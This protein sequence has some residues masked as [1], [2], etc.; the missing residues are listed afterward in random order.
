[1]SLCLSLQFFCSA[2]I[3]VELFTRSLHKRYLCRA[4]EIRGLCTQRWST[5][6]VYSASAIEVLFTALFFIGWRR[7]IECLKS[8]VIFLKEPLIIGLFCGKWPI[9]DKAS[10]GFLPPYTTLCLHTILHR[11][12]QSTLSTVVYQSRTPD[13]CQALTVLLQYESRTLDSCQALTVLLQYQ[14]RTLDSWHNGGKNTLY[15]TVEYCVKTQRC[16]DTTLYKVL[17]SRK[18]CIS[19]ELLTALCLYNVLSLKNT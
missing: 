10:Y 19:H 5:L 12:V 17:R 4:V 3:C 11:C 13:S 6:R 2:P 7:L 8:Q 18:H 14:S 1:M 9:K 16:K 15:T